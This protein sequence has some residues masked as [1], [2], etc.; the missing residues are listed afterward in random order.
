MRWLPALLAEL[1]RPGKVDGQRMQARLPSSD[2]RWGENWGA[3]KLACVKARFS[4]NYFSHCG[5]QFSAIDP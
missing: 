2:V 4:G 3:H 5:D 1:D